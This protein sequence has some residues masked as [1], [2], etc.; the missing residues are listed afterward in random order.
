MPLEH[1][2]SKAAVGRNIERERAAGKPEKQAVAI[3]LNV[4]RE[5][6]AKDGRYVIPGKSGAVKR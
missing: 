4:Q 2:K 5:A 6:G 1:S 3:A